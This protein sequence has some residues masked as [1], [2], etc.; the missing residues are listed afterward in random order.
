MTA[1]IGLV[2]P[3]QG[4]QSVGMGK[5][6]YDAVPTLKALYEEASSVLGYDVASLCFE[7]PAERL[8]L[9]EFTQP[10][11]LVSS[12]AALKALEP[13]QIKPVAVAGHSLGE[14]SALVAAGGVSFRD[15]VGLVQKRGRYMTEAV[16]PG[17]GLVA[18]LLGLT[19]DVVRQVCREASVAGVVAAANFNSPGQVVIAGE[20]AAVERAIELAKVRGCRKAIPLPVSVPV[21]TPLMRSAADRLAKDLAAVQW[22][23]LTAPLINNADA[24]VI[25]RAQDIHPSLVRQLPSSVLWEDSVHAMAHLG[26]TTF[27]EVGPGTVLTGL[28]KRI[29]PDAS[30]LNVYDPQ[31]LESTVHSLK[32]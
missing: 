31:S 20:K 29:L 15:A 14:Y 23:D 24:T 30:V 6:L 19:A 4:S 7:G 2:F 17:T 13:A 16:P 9:T 32:R 26:V 21:H 5:A 25:R 1:G 27:I 12:V 3:G 28:I 22:S 18:A 8:N 10:A 11:L